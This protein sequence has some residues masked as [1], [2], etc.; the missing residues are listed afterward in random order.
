M[1]T[2]SD[3]TS[4]FDQSYNNDCSFVYHIPW[5]RTSEPPQLLLRCLPAAL[6]SVVEAQ[7]LRGAPVH[8][9]FTTITLC[10]GLTNVTVKAMIDYSITH[11]ASEALPFFLICFL[12]GIVRETA[13]TV[14]EEPQTAEPIVEDSQSAGPTMEDLQKELDQIEERRKKATLAANLQQARAAELAG[15]PIVQV[16]PTTL[17]L[18]VRTKDE[19]AI[20]GD[21]IR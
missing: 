17:T 5:R 11:N 21:S 10:L 1:R 14:V 2:L 18:P 3:R 7:A 4:H 9:L 20:C 16:P 12:G 15:F 13:R 6:A 19:D 8:H